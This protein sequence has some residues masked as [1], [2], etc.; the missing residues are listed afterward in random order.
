MAQRLADAFIDR[1]A[2]RLVAVGRAL[3][4][5]G[6]LAYIHRADLVP[7]AMVAACLAERSAEIDG[8][9]AEGTVEAA[10]AALFKSRAEALCV[11]TVGGGQGPRPAGSIGHIHGG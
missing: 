10:R 4:C 11:A 1:Q 2:A 3:P 5:A 7:A 9:V 8:M 6:A